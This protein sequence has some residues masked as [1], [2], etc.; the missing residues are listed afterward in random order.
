MRL[1]KC[2]KCG[3][4]IATDETFI[5]R[6]LDDIN[7]LLEKSRKD[8]RNANSYMQQASAIRK[9]M[10]QYLHR[11]AQM[12]E[13]CRR[14][15][16]EHKALVHYVLDN[17]I[18]TQEKLQEIDDIARKDYEE[19]QREDQEVINQLY[20]GFEN[21]TINRTKSDPVERRALRGKQDA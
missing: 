5:Q 3:T 9:I 12:D 11:T 7:I 4:T 19:R 10:Q 16:H 14:L 2:R 8:R 13:Q 15:I 17:G 6:M 18:V 20:R 21:I 1:I